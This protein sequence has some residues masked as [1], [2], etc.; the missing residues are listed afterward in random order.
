L[1]AVIFN[2][3]CS[4]D[5]TNTIQED[6]NFYALTV[7]NSW[8]YT[9][10]LKDTASND[11][12]P[13]TVT[14]T[15]NITETVVI[16]NKTY[17]NFKHVVTGNDGNYGSLPNNGEH[18]YRLRDSLGFLIDQAGGIK[19]NNSNNAE[20]FINTISPEFSYY[21]SLSDIEDDITT[22]AGSFLCYDNHYYLKDS[23][24]NVSSALNH[25][26]RASGKGEI[27]STLL[28]AI[29]SKPF[30]ENRLEFYSLQ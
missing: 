5:D 21:L 6:T 2:Y 11:F 24:G 1:L 27:L 13:T 22:N 9:Y 17:Y 16:D 23:N 20:Y 15:V 19:Y 30:A 12:L 26:Y 18:N 7:G 29:Q 28:F 8:E 3:A 4:S 10:Y 25:N 14:E